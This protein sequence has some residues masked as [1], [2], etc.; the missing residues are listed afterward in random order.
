[1]ILVRCAMIH[2]HIWKTKPR[3]PRGKP[4]YVRS[5]ASLKCQSV[6]SM[7]KHSYMDV[8][9]LLDSVGAG[10]LLYI[11]DSLTTRTVCVPPSTSPYRTLN[12]QFSST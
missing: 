9:W 10:E 8:L 3:D 11:T 2:T 7:Q 6:C 4:S 5:D 1:M 12:K